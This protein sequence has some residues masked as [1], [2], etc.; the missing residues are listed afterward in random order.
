[1]TINGKPHILLVN[2]DGI[3]SPGLWAAAE[4]LAPI[5][6][7]TVAAPRH[8]WSGAGR[9]LPGSSDGVIKTQTLNVHGKD[10]TVYAIGGS[11]AQT[12]IHAIHEICPSKPDLVVSGINYGE[13]AGTG[14]TS[15]GTVGA[16]LE[17]A[18]YG[19]PALA[20]S[21]EVVADKQWSFSRSINFEGAKHFTQLFA[22]KL[23][24][25]SMPADV[26]VIKVEVPDDA[27]ESTTWKVTRL[28]RKPYYRLYIKPRTDLEQPLSISYEV[29]RASSSTVD[30]A[31]TDNYALLVDRCVAVTPLSLDMTSRTDMNDL[32]NLLG[33]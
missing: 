16:A 19:I 3:N 27:D 12:V 15:S 28:C 26:D 33:A 22:K 25:R 13:N 6:Y 30:N 9:S 14:V 21:L 10:W 4:A 5:G 7:V 1:M 29:D 11:P 24:D 8:Q 32:Q 2:D 18:S 23:L 20:I 17:A 31:G